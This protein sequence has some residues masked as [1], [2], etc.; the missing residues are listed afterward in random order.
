MTR[1]TRLNAR[2]TAAEKEMLVQV[3]QAMQRTASDTLRVLVYEKARELEVLLHR[4]DTVPSPP[5]AQTAGRGHAD[6]HDPRE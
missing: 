6:V 2:C 4:P 1:D 5:I 3:A